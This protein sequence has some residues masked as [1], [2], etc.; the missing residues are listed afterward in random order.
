MQRWP[1]NGECGLKVCWDVD[2]DLYDVFP[3][4]QGETFSK[5]GWIH[6][7][8]LALLILEKGVTTRLPDTE[9]IG[10]PMN[11]TGWTTVVPKLCCHW[12]EEYE[13]LLEKLTLRKVTLPETHDSGTYKP[14]SASPLVKTQNLSLTKQLHTCS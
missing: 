13:H 7:G 5:L 3:P 8:S 14:V 12:M 2:T 4:D 10:V 11:V 6:D 1:R 9:S